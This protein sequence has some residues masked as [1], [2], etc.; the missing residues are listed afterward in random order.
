MT[1]LPSAPLPSAPL[2]SAPLAS[3]P[4][5]GAEQALAA[6]DTASVERHPQIFTHFDELLREALESP[7]QVGSG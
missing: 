2:P 5:V 3:D 7:P 6:L 4:L 1:P